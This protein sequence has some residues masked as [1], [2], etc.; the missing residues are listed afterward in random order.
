MTLRELIDQLGTLRGMMELGEVDGDEPVHLLRATALAAP[1][2]L[3]AKADLLEQ[4]HGKE[5]GPATDA[6]R[7]ATRMHRYPQRIRKLT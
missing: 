1:T 5:S 7:L 2:A 4:L 3:N 6:R